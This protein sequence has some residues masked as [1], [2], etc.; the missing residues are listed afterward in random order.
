LTDATQHW[1]ED[2][3]LPFSECLC[4]IVLNSVSDSRHLFFPQQN[5]EEI[6]ALKDF[7]SNIL[8]KK[9]TFR[10]IEDAKKFKNHRRLYRK[11]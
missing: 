4:E 7:E 2:I 1:L 11:Y 9:N 8:F 10:D 5:V 3:E 6:A